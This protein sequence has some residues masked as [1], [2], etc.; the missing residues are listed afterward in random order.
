MNVQHSMLKG[1]FDFCLIVNQAVIAFKSY[2]IF[3]LKDCT[4]YSNQLTKNV[5]VTSAC[6]LDIHW[7]KS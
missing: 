7:F 5:Y 2:F 6:Y 4:Q 3:F 1:D